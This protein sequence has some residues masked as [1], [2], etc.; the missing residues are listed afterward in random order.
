ML[1]SGLKR[2]WW[3]LVVPSLLASCTVLNPYGSR[4]HEGPPLPPRISY[5]YTS[6]S[7]PEV[8]KTLK[9]LADYQRILDQYIESISETILD[10]E[11]VSL[12]DR[13]QLCKASAYL[14][15]IELP[16]KP[17]LKDDGREDDDQIIVKLVQYIKRLTEKITGH[18]QQVV[19]L[20]KEYNRLCLI[21]QPLRN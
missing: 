15:E 20:R 6:M 10:K 7:P 18:N 5:D 9:H 1:V 21:R 8:E 19:S 11:Y 13:A 16:P 4:Y 14:H 17:I 3:Y 12:D 2:I